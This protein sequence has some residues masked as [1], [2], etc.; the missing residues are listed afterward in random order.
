MK[1]IFTNTIADTIFNRSIEK[2][3]SFVLRQK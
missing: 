1:F 3:Y 2:E